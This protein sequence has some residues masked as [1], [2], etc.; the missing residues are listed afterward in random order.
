MY[1]NASSQFD[2]HPGL[3]LPF[4]ENPGDKKYNNKNQEKGPPHASF[5]NAFH[6]AATRKKE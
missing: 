6:H 2:R 1:P 5:K 4:K 3:F